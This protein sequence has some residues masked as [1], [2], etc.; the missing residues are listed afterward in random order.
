MKI[1]R[2]LLFALPIALGAQQQQVVQEAQPEL[3]TFFV[4]HELRTDSDA[5]VRFLLSAP[6]G[7]QGFV[8]VADGH[9]VTP[10]GKRFRMWGVN[11]TGWTVGS[12]LLPSN[13]DA[14]VTARS[15][16]QVGVNCVRFQFLDLTKQQNRSPGNAP[17]TYTP[18]GLLDGNADTSQV[19]DPGQFDR[20][21]YLVN[22]LKAHGIYVDLNLNVGRRY[23][24][25]DDVHDYDLIGVAKAITQFDPRLIALQKDYARQL[26]THLNPYTTTEYRNEP[27]IAIVEIVNENSVLEFWQ[28]NWFRGKLVHGAP[29]FQLDLTPYHKTLLTQLYNDWLRKTYSAAELE[30]LR[31]LAGLHS[32]Q[33]FSL[34]QRQDFAQTPKEV[35][36]AESRFYTHVET[37]FLEDMRSYL[38]QTLGVKSLIIGGNDHTY[39]IPGMPLVRSTS[40][41]DIVDAHVYW[42][43]PAITGRRNT[44]MVD[45]PLH[46]IA[47]KLTRS[48]FS[49][50]PFTVSEVNEPFP[51][52]YQAEMIPIL[53]AYGAFQDWDG[54]FIYTFEPKVS[55]S[56]EAAVGDHFDLA[57][58]PVKMAQLPVGALLF[59]RHDVD[60]ARKT[61]ERTYSIEQISESMRLP[62]S[63]SPY[64]T[65]GF[66]LSLPLEHGSRI[67]CLDCQ[68]GEMFHDEPQNPIRSDTGQLAWWRSDGKGGLVMIDTDRT[69]ALVGFVRDNGG[70]T[71]HLAADVQNKFCALTLSSLD[72]QPISQS[73]L[74]LLTATG[75]VE[76]TGA[77][78]NARRTMLDVWGTAPTRLEVIKGW[79]TL[80]QLDGAVGVLVTP[81]DGSAKPLGETRGRRL[82]IGWEIAIGD[83]PATSYL[84]RIVR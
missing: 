5:D 39:F 63:E 62:E 1:F 82:D 58:D 70:N 31:S 41:M 57:E 49:N 75:R 32:G 33:P 81:L 79:L 8:T 18:S 59:L 56:W 45:D 65:P 25:G 43:H 78:W 68:P 50:K 64:Y 9:L 2:F 73:S 20:F 22:Q 76:N 28:R 69:T 23:K 46:S 4:N 61:I 60:A 10:D 11:M 34:T 38:K 71:S 16:A 67:R 17:T 35:F 40:L 6:A 53:A 26:L 54:I 55:G 48:T 42:Q 29:A 19:M 80:K 36:Y 21:D 14:E 66:P 27:A 52:D 24:K 84:I 13:H 15:L 7:K 12:A 74:L 83:K 37:S 47:V 77:V 51:S 72:T 3:Q 44:P 30:H